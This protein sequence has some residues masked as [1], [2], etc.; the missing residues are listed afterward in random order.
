MEAR[1]KGN[2]HAVPAEVAGDPIVRP[3]R[4]VVLRP[5]QATHK[6]Y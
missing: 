1:S 4:R 5:G 6:G 2:T 3:F